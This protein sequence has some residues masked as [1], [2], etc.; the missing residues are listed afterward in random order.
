M[1][2]DLLP[3]VV[4]GPVRMSTE[5]LLASQSTKLLHVRQGTSKVSSNQFPIDP[6]AQSLDHID[7][8]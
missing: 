3:V 5:V 6:D 4:S 7:E 1:E 2:E 8:L